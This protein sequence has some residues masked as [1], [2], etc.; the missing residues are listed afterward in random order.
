MG[1]SSRWSTRFWS[2]PQL[3]WHISY[4]EIRVVYLTLHHFLDQLKSYHVLVCKCNMTLVS[5]I[6]HQDELH[7]HPLYRQVQQVLLWTETKYL[8]L[9]ASF[10]PGYL[11]LGEDILTRQAP[12]GLDTM[13]Q[14]WLMLHL[15]TFLAPLLTVLA[16]VCQEQV[17][18]ILAPFWPARVWLLDLNSLLD[19]TPCEVPISF[20][21]GGWSS[22]PGW[23]S[24]SF[25]PSPWRVPAHRLGSF[26]WDSG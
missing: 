12:L 8:F 15:Y 19:G 11:Y 5:Y 20:K 6:N 18:R 4:L 22:I 2:D 14:V 1:C 13:V 3:S 23:R 7:S 25:G 24:R 10:V 17:H 9:R 26:S 16:R 21:S